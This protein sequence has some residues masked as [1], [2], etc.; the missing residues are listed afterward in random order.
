MGEVELGTFHFYPHWSITDC[1]KTVKECS[2]H[3]APA[4]E[5]DSTHI[6]DIFIHELCDTL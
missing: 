4:E 5:G 2:R 3:C 1:G 6:M